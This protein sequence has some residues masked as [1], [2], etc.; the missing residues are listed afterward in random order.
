MSKPE[1]IGH[2]GLINRYF[3]ETLPHW[4][5]VYRSHDLSATRYQ[6]RKATVLAMVDSLHLGLDSKILE[7]GCGAGATTVALAQ[8]GYH[9]NA[10]DSV[11]GMIEQTRELANENN[12]GDRVCASLIDVH[13]LAFPDEHFDLVLAVGVI[14]WMDSPTQ[15]LHEMLRVTKPGAYL[16]VTASNRWRLSH[17]LDP[18]CFPP[19]RPIRLKIRAA[20]EQLGLRSRR[21][22]IPQHSLHSPGEVDEMLL[23]AGAYKIRGTTV[24]FG[25]FT[26]L[27]MRVF[28]EATGIRIHQYFQ[29][30]ANRGTPVFRSTG[31]GYIVLAQKFHAHHPGLK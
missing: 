23:S 22:R 26:F 25:P 21:F 17:I 11:S 4:R 20:L 13:K 28:S 12:V 30:L 27:N 5:D 14:P 18:F 2:Q 8:R 31:E 7:V 24:G 9:V 29:E 6:Q 10:V 1:R 19:L 15:P 16:L 3:Q